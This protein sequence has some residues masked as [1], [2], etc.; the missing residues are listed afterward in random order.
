MTLQAV[1]LVRIPGWEAD[2]DLDVRELEDGALVFL[3]IPFESEPEDVVEALADALGP[4]M[5]ALHDDE[6]GVFVFPDAA[7]PEDAATYDAVLE[8][9][10]ELGAFLP[11]DSDQ[12][13]AFSQEEAAEALQGALFGTLEK[14][15]A[16]LG[17]GSI[18]ELQSL[19]TTNDPDAL[20]MAQIR[21]TGMMERAMAPA[22]DGGAQSPATDA[23]DATDA[24]ATAKAPKKDG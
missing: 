8:A 21:M 11:L 16:Q 23:T 18:E 2:D 4:A 12:P 14:A 6:R 22:L 9:V 24:T 19:L 5:L 10:G 20:K 15:V 3:E 17:F 1:A 7:E 13:L